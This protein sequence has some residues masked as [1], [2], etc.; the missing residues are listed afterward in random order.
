MKIKFLSLVAFLFLL[1]SCSSSNSDVTPADSYYVKVKIDGK[2]YE[3]SG[4]SVYAINTTDTYNVYATFDTKR[5][6][7]FQLDK[8][9]GVGTHTANANPNFVFFRD[10]T[11]T[12][13]RS[14]YTGGTGEV[15]ITEKT[16][17]VVKGK[18]KCTVKNSNNSTKVYTFT[19][20]DFVVK[21]NK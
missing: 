8:A 1:G 3:A 20:G 10:E 19:E 7:Y 13:N 5:T 12:I 21:F 18:F 6:M 4:I 17:D 15:Q 9:K 11:E 2:D 16:A 14:D